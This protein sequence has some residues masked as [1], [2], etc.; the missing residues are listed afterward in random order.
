MN[1]KPMV[2]MHKESGDLF[3]EIAFDPSKPFCIMQYG[4]GP[5]DFSLFF[6]DRF[7]CLGEL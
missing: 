1:N 3:S 5:N 6:S 2:F 4:D 7:E